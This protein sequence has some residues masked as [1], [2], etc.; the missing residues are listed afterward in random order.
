MEIIQKREDYV[1]KG[2]P[3]LVSGRG[4]FWIW[5]F[6][7][8]V[9]T[10]LPFTQYPLIIEGVVAIVSLGIIYSENLEWMNKRMNEY[11]DIFIIL[12][13]HSDH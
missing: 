6:N 8:V 4:T 2:L 3:R 1:F 12:S 7:F 11:L 10:I 9:Q 5:F 13:A